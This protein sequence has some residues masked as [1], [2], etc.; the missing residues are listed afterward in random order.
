[1][2]NMSYCRFENTLRDLNDCAEHIWDSLESS[3]GNC[4]EK[5]IKVCREIVKDAGDQY[6]DE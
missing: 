3:E 1:M 2:G 5:L 6:D 4:R